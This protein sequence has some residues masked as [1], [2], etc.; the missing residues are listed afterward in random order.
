MVCERG[1]SSGWNR[2]ACS[3][4]GC[5]ILVTVK[6]GAARGRLPSEIAGLLSPCTHSSLPACRRKP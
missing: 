6:T 2:R 4:C 3:P 5:G 1:G